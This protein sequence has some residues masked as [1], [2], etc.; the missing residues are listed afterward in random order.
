[1]GKTFHDTPPTAS[2]SVRVKENE[3]FNSALRRFK[4]KVA[5]AG[6]I[7]EVRDRQYYEQPSQVRKKAKAAGRARTI[8]KLNQAAPAKKF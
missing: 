6:V 2:I 5:D 3:S 4:K 7:Q 1:M 8:R